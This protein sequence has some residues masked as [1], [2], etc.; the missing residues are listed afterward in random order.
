MCLTKTFEVIK[1]KIAFQWDAI[2]PLVDRISQHA[3]RRGGC[4]LWGVSGS[5]VGGVWS[6]GSAPGGGGGIVACTEADPPVDRI[7]D[8][9]LKILPCPKLRLRAVIILIFLRAV[10]N[11]E[12]GSPSFWIRY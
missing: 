7:L 11:P 10:A 1:N 5:R 2:R 12:G 4:L 8:T 9:L 3:L 6:G